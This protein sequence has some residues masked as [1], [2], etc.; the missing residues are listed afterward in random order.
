MSLQ[1]RRAA[2]VSLPGHRHGHAPAKGV[3]LV[4]FLAKGAPWAAPN[5]QTVRENGSIDSLVLTDL[6]SDHGG[7][8]EVGD[9]NKE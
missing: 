3:H 7:T 6:L 2:Q 4:S 8:D 1:K 5:R 9:W